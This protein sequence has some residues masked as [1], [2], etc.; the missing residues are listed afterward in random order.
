[1]K[2]VL[3]SI[4]DLIRASGPGAAAFAAVAFVL[5]Y[6]WRLDFKNKVEEMNKDRDRLIQVVV[7]NTKS[8]EHMADSNDKLSAAVERFST[9]TQGSAEAYTRQIDGL[10]QIFRD[11]DRERERR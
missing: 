9:T 11:R 3:E 2:E 4:V 5:L 6:M 7:D 10:V 8:I 1:M